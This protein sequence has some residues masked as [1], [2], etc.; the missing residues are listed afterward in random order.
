MSG[1]KQHSPELQAGYKSSPDEMDMYQIYHILH[2]GTAPDAIGTAAGTA[3]SGGIAP[4]LTE[5]DYP[6]NVLFSYSA[7]TTTG[8][9]LVVKGQDQFGGTVTETIAVAAASGGGTTAGTSIFARVGTM[10]Y[11]KDS[12]TGTLDVG[13]AIGTGASTPVF[14]LPNKISGSADIKHGL[15]IDND[16]AKVMTREGTASPALVAVQSIH[17]VRIEVT[18]GIVPADSFI[19]TYKPTIDL[20][21]QGYQANL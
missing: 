17:A 15:W 9:T 3:V 2:A 10:T 5:L 11:T 6:R 1:L 20:S 12:Q 16:V 14:G 19:V 13:Y 21:S 4:L 8:A 7:G 18:G